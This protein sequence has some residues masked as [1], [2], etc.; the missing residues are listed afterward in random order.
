MDILVKRYLAV[1]TYE[2][3]PRLLLET[4]TAKWSLYMKSPKNLRFDKYSFQP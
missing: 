4:M 3:K 1:R 2:H